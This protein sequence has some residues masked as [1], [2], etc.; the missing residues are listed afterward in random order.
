MTLREAA[1]QLGVQ[2]DTLR[3]QVRLGKLKA[4]KVGR[5]WHVT[6]KEVER[7]RLESR[8]SS[9]QPATVTTR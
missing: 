5:D 8:R 7:Y 6:P 1:E 3:R 9:Q 4:R 2:P